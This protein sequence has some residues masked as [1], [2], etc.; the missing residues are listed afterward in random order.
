ME[1]KEL[2]LDVSK[3]LIQESR[4]TTDQYNEIYQGN[5]IVMQLLQNPGVDDKVRGKRIEEVHELYET[6]RGNK[7]FM[8]VP[9]ISKIEENYSLYPSIVARD[10]RTLE[11]IGILTLKYHDREV[12]GVNPFNPEKDKCFEMSGV[13]VKGDTGK[14]NIGTYLYKTAVE[15]VHAYSR[16]NENIPL[17]MEIDCRNPRSFKA[18]EKAVDIKNSESESGNKTN[19]GLAGYYTIEDMV[20]NEF[21]DPPIFVFNVEFDSENPEKSESI[22]IKFE[23]SGAP[24]ELFENLRVTAEEELSS[25]ITSELVTYED[26][27]KIT[28][29]RI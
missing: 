19:A 7:H 29:K 22:N 5:E 26:G 1:N 2:F 12:D 11:L 4:K 25:Y 15:A 23:R 24:E 16:E 10:K 6:W 9:S 27:E 18:L 8:L 20:E 17:S 21:I 28:F 14:K 3:K 13:Y